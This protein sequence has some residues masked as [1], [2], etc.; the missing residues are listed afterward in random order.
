MSSI[1][2][3]VSGT[4][5]SY[6]ATS[7]TDSS[8]DWK[9]DAYKNWYVTISGV[10]Y[11]IE[12]NTSD[13]LTFDNTLSSLEDYEISIVGREYLTEI[14]SDCSNITKIP[15]ALIEKKYNQAN[16][17]LYNK[18]FAYLRKLCV[19]EFDPMENI[20][21]IE[22]MQQPYAYYM[23]YLIYTDLTILE[24]SFNTFK[25]EGFYEQYKN[26]VKDS[27]SLIQVDFNEDGVADCDEKNSS[28]GGTTLIR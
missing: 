5:T 23:L 1:F 9:V 20:L 17:D 24:G 11:R 2:D 13:T 22:I 6:T 8:V 25:T 4:Y 10:E 27:L 7:I 21:N 3:K 28:V 19:D 26:T 14:E 15:D 16:I 18:T 12:S